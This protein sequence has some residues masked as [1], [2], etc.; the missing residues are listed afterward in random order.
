[1][2]L[3]SEFTGVI[4]IK[5]A[6]GIGS[7]LLGSIRILWSKLDKLEKKLETSNKEKLDLVIKK[8]EENKEIALAFLAE[9]E[10]RK[11]LI[12]S[13]ELIIEIVSNLKK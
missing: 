10:G 13:M 8:A 5:I 9:K 1:M 6:I 7:I 12:K 4:D 3:L 2:I 11:E